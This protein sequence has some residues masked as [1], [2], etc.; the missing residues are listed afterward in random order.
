MTDKTKI[1]HAY[2]GS[3]VEIQFLKNELEKMG[4]SVSIKNEY[5]EALN[6]GFGAGVP[7]TS[8]LYCFQKDKEKVM[9]VIESFKEDNS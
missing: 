3:I 1:V 2:S 7:G 6:A 5:A 9:K 8:D 4:I